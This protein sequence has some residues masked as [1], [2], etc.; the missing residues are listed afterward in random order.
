M[1]Y[2]AHEFFIDGQAHRGQ[3]G[4]LDGVEQFVAQFEAAVGHLGHAADNKCIRPFRFPAAEINGRG[5]A[6]DFHRI[7]QT[8]HPAALQVGF[9]NGAGR[10]AADAFVRKRRH[11]DRNLVC[12]YARNVDT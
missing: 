2:E 5:F 11:G 7:N 9:N 3:L 8:K 12:A 10:L 4:C 6:D 1:R